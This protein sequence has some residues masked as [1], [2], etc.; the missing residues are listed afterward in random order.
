MNGDDVEDFSGNSGLH[1]DFP[2]EVY[3]LVLA[4][5]ENGGMRMVPEEG[6]EP[7][8]GLTPPDF[9]FSESPHRDELRRITVRTFYVASFADASLS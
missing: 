2:S 6:L 7:S 3:T 5:S 1:P 9:E 4:S 8:R